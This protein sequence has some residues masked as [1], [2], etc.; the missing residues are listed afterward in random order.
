M[1]PV[2]WALAVIGV[3]LV[4]GVAWAAWQTWHVNKS[5]SAA[6][7]D[8]RTLQAAL[9]AGDQSGVDQSL[10]R[11]KIHAG[12]ADDRTSGPIWS[13]MTHAPVYGDD[14]SGVRVVS[15]VLDDL[16]SQ[17]FAQLANSATDLDAY[18]PK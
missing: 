15:S 13:L 4:L 3:L 11:L 5:L 12:D 9:S 18:L 17:G 2:R 1:R 8:A 6:A 14:A 16:T 10:D 7:D